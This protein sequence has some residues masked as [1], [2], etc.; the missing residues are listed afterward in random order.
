MPGNIIAENDHAKILCAYKDEMVQELHA[1]LDYWKKYTVDNEHGGFYGSVDTNN[2]PGKTA[3]KG[4]VLNSRILWAFSAAYNYTKDQSDFNTATIAFEYII[5][6]FLDHDYGGVFWSTDFNGKMLDGRKQIYGFAFCIYGMSEYYKVSGNGMALHIAKDLFDNIEQYSFDKRHD[7]YIEA[8]TR[9]WTSLDDLRLS[10]KDDNAK[11]TMNTHL[12][13]AEAYANL[14]QVWPDKLLKEKITGLL[15]IIDKYFINENNYHLNLFFTEDW[16]LRS[17]LQSFGHDIEA[18]W[19]LQQ[20]AE[21]S[22]NILQIDQY[23]ELSLLLTAAAVEGLHKDGGLWY[24]YDPANNELIKEKHWWAQAEAMVGFF[25]SYQLSGNE[26]YLQQ[27]LNSWQFV[28]NYIKDSKKGEWFW[29]I[30]EDY[31]VMQKDKTG[32][33]KCPYHNTRAFLEII[34]RIEKNIKKQKIES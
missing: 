30:N 12:H 14:Y 13:I 28:K 5:D 23:K 1:T 31:S 11:K 27:S 21:I 3:P 6:H 24:E 7:G 20:C 15:D 22:G 25:N 33:W 4:I 29:G 32:F 19:L 18:A 26:L 17:S 10:E 9:E 2:T 34:N 8:F 16:V